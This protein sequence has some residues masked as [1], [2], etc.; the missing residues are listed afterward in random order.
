M[1][2]FMMCVLSKL[3]EIFLY[4]LLYVRYHAFPWSKRVHRKAIGRTCSKIDLLLQ[5]FWISWLFVSLRVP[6]TAYTWLI[7]ALLSWLIALL[8][9]CICLIAL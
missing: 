8:G 5:C 1:P 9:Y 4:E 7:D 3:K 2:A 6:I